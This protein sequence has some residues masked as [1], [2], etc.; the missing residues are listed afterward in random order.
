MKKKAGQKEGS[1]NQRRQQSMHGMPEQYQKFSGSKE[2][3][4][5]QASQK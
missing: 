3:G 5:Q 1:K 4:N 2:R